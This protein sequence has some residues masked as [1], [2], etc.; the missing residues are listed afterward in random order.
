M[1]HSGKNIGNF[2]WSGEN[3]FDMQ[4]WPSSHF[5]FKGLP[6]IKPEFMEGPMER[7]KRAKRLLK[8][9]KGISKSD[10]EDEEWTPDM[11]RN[12]RLKGIL[13][14]VTWYI[15][16]FQIIMAIKTIVTFFLYTYLVVKKR[17]KSKTARV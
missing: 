13:F 11:E 16:R 1:C 9:E 3:N 7:G 2:T 14:T 10:N 6:A 15:C 8:L 4:N 17:Y 12:K 5:C